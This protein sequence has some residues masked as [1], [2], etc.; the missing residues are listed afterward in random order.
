MLQATFFSTVVASY[1]TYEVKVKKVLKIICV[2][3]EEL[4]R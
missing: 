4:K 2:I 3:P 1:T